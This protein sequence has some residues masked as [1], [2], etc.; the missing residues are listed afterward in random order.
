MSNAVYDDGILC[1]PHWLPIPERDSYGYAPLNEVA[2]RTEM[3]SGSLVRLKYKVDQINISCQCIMRDCEIAW[4]EA[5]EAER[6]NQGIE[7]FLMPIWIA[8]NVE[9]YMVQFTDRPAVTQVQG[10][11]N[12]MSLKLRIKS[13]R[14][15]PIDGITYGDR[16]TLVEWP[17]NLPILQDGYS[18]EVRKT[19]MKGATQ[20]PTER[21]P[22]LSIDEVTITGKCSLSISQSA[23]F[24]WF[25]REILNMGARWFKMP[26]W[27]SGE[28]KAYKVRFKSRPS[29]A[30]NGLWTDATFEL[31]LE[32]RELMH[33]DVVNWL[34]YFS[35]DELFFFL[36][37]FHGMLHVTMPGLTIIPDGVYTKV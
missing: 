31:E 37:N 26:V 12:W 19:D 7:W 17:S 4:L 13:R 18:Y 6:L 3:D 10:F 25:E 22:E 35:P 32:Q 9:H 33:P 23:V 14:L 5:F 20:L 8:G 29:F 34:L 36:E 1:W 28:L 15:P 16:R 21:R 24:E 2:S 27:I 30:L 11:D